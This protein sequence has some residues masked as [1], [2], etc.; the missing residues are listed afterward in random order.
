MFHLMFG[1]LWLYLCL[2]WV[3]RLPL[4]QRW[5]LIVAGALLG[6]SQYHLLQKALFGNMF[7]PEMPRALVIAASTAFITFVLLSILVIAGDISRGLLRLIRH[8]NKAE[9]SVR[10]PSSA[11]QTAQLIL[12]FLIADVGV[13]QA[14]RVPEVRHLDVVIQALPSSMDGFRI[15]QLSDL[16]LSRMLDDDWARAVVER[17]NTLEPDLILITGDLID[18]TPAARQ[19][20]VKPLAGLKASHGV[21]VSPGNHEYY[22][23][24]PHWR[25]AFERLGLQVLINEHRVINHQDGG[26]IIAAVTDEAAPQFGQQPPNLNDALAGISPQLP[27]ILMKHRPSGAAQS[28]AAGVDLQLSGHTHGGMIRGFDWLVSRVN[29]GYVAGAYEVGEMTLYTQRGTGIWNGFPVRLGV[30]SE[31]TGITLRS[32]QINRR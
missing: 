11:I 28:E 20:D 7:S 31:I 27:I 3:W 14:L 23:N 2:R 10:K 30:P 22:F 6:I 24:E 9:V 29:E 15:V 26:L 12:A 16:H 1:L 4:A 13:Q 25:A 21:F 18:G 19:Q 17:T 8:A 32:S 5:R